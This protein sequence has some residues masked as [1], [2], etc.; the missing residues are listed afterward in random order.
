MLDYLVVGLGLAGVSICEA[1]EENGHSFHVISDGKQ[2]ASTVAGGVYNPV[3][4]NRFKAVWKGDS[5]LDYALPFYRDLEVKLNMNFLEETTLKRRFASAEEQNLWFE[6][7]SDP[8]LKRFLSTEI[9]QNTNEALIAPYG[10]GNVLETGRV[11]VPKLVQKYRENLSK[12]GRHSLETFDMS[13]L[14]LTKDAVRYRDLKAKR[15]IWAIGHRNTALTYFDYIPLVGNKGELL[16]IKA[17]ELQLDSLIKGPVFILPIGD[18]LYKVGA[19]YD[20]SDLTYEPTQAARIRLSEQLESMISCP[21]E[22]VAQ[23]AGIRP[24]VPDRRPLLGRHPQYNNLVLYNG[25]GSRGVL[26]APWLGRHLWEYLEKGKELLPELSI[27]RYEK[28]YQRL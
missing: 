25:L 17:L 10:F 22:I 5:F 13:A 26:M 6:A 28:R 21:Y 8:R 9:I 1:L 15:I 2:M 27:D 4:L 12:Q 24:T 20:R 14:D 19:T 11:N 18:D 3:V 23:E 16:T 7:A